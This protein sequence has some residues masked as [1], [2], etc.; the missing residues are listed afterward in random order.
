MAEDGAVLLPVLSLNEA[1]ERGKSRYHLVCVRTRGRWK[2]MF[3]SQI[4]FHLLPLLEPLR[5]TCPGW[6]PN[7]ASTEGGEPSSKE[8]FY[9]V[10]NNYSE[11]LYMRCAGCHFRAPK[12][13]ISGPAPYNGPRIGNCPPQKHYSY[14]AMKTTG[15]LMVIADAVP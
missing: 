7:P 3:Y 14:R 6:E 13:S 10:I 8:L 1:G 12:V 2:F 4:T 5:L 11:H 15:T 9:Q